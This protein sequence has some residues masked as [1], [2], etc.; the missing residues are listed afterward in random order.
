MN[1][2]DCLP[3]SLQ[4]KQ[5]LNALVK[6]IQESQI[7]PTM[8]VL[9]GSYARAEYKVGSDL[10]ILILS[11]DEIPREL[12]G[13]LCS[14]FE[15]LNSDLVFYTNDVFYESN[16]LLVQQIRRDGVLLWKN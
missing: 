15:E 5:K 7:I 4:T 13:E 12:R 2:V 11:D 10:D 14:R 8:I 3:Y 16:S 9:F 1:Y 6:L